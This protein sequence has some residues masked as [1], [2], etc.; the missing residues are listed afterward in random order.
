MKI[1]SITRE[2]LPCYIREK[3]SSNNSFS[4]IVEV[5]S[6]EGSYAQL[7]H[8]SFPYASITLVDMWETNGN[9]FYYS[10]RPGMVENA[11]QIASKRFESYS[12]VRL[13]KGK[14]LEASSFFENESI[15]FIYIDAD[16]SYEGCLQDL[17]AWYPK[18]KAGGVIAGHDWDC[19]PGLLEYSRFGVEKAVRQ[20]FHKR[21]DDIELTSE[22][23][24]K[25]W[26]LVK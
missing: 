25:S 4:T 19:E 7:I 15:N 3:Y 16:H 6:F 1:L 8:S 23:F 21:L 11:F 20:F 14:S 24:H 26:I 2:D 13:L 5:G 17:N 10:V 22:S 12:N 18:V 9:D